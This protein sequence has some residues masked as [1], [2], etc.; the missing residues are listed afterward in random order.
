MSILET[1]PAWPHALLYEEF[2][3]RVVS[4]YRD[5]LKRSWKSGVIDAYVFNRGNSALNNCIG[6]TSRHLDSLYVQAVERFK[7]S[8]DKGRIAMGRDKYQ[9]CM[10]N[11]VM[12]I[13]LAE[14]REVEATPKAIR[15][16]N[17]I[18]EGKDPNDTK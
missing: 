18:L 6:K 1:A 3:K 7:K 12:C 17:A 15:I 16:T 10:G 13:H 5:E 4:Y 9:F 2:L 14:G 8:T 11:V